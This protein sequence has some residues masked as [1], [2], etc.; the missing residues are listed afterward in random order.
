MKINY[1]GAIGILLTMIACEK[2]LTPTVVNDADQI[3]VEGYI[4]AGI[5]KDA[6]RVTPPYVILTRAVPFQKEFTTN[7]IFVNGA[8]VTVSNGTD[9]VKLTEF[10]WQNLDSV[11]KRRAAGVFGINFDSVQSNF[12]VCLYLDLTQRMKGQIGKSYWLTIKKDGKTVTSVTTIPKWIPIDSSYFIK[13]PGTNQNDT[14]VQMRAY[15]RDIANELNYY[16]YMVGINGE[17]YKAGRQSVYTDELIDGQYFLFNLFNREQASR[18]LFRRGDTLS[19]KWSNIDGE[20][21]DF[22]RTLEFNANNQGPFS[23]YTR[24][25]SNIQG[26]MG[27][28]GGAVVSYLDTIVPKK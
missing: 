23:A 6:N 7:N 14:M 8:D 19:V 17:P 5:G 2:E 21:Y 4:E 15:I 22:W 24:V 25:K 26:G 20:Q 3:V 13:P 10:C 28:W 12:N 1:I 16:R 9:S 27:I 18:G 11:T